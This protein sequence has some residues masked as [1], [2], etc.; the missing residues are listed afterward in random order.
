[1][2][3]SE[4][5]TIRDFMIVPPDCSIIL[6]RLLEPCGPLFCAQTRPVP[7]SGIAENSLPK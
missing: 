6:V 2:I 4:L 1:M 5:I 7:S 3:A